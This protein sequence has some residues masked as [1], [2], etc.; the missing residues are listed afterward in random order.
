[1]EGINLG[2]STYMW[3]VIYLRAASPPLFSLTA[4]RLFRVSF[5]PIDQR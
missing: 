2:L 1:M 5:E 3:G 4:I